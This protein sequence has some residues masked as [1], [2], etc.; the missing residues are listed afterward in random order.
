MYNYK[1]L[2]AGQLPQLA[3]EVDDNLNI[4]VD[5]CGPCGL[6]IVGD[7]KIYQCHLIKR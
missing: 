2:Q 3:Q 5:E 4:R 6:S 7:I 1:T